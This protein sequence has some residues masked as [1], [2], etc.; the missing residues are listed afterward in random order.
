MH[1]HVWSKA[2]IIDGPDQIGEVVTVC[3]LCGKIKDDEDV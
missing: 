1:E 2:K 3:A